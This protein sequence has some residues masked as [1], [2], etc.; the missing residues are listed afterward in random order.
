MADKLARAQLARAANALKVQSGS[1]LPAL[2]LMTDDERLADP[3]AAARTLPRGSMVILRAR[4]AARR[5]RLAEE[6]Q[7]VTRAK[8][9][10]LLIA[11]DPALAMR[12]GADGIHLPQ[13]RARSAAHWRAL[14]PS[15]IITAAARSPAATHIPAADAILLSPVFATKSHPGG[16]VLGSLRM[17]LIARNARLPIYAL[18]GID[19]FSVRAVAGAR[20][21]GIAAIGALAA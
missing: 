20:L 18:G 5:A 11:D 8:G 9:I 15:W 16:K 4:D 14:R 6:L 21:A 3:L 12:I 1:A 7:R 10:K 19:R 13:A 17:R 2:V